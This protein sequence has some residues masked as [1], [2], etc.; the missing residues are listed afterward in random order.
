MV[1]LK[2]SDELAPKEA[3]EEPAMTTLTGRAP[4]ESL[5]LSASLPLLLPPLPLAT[6]LLTSPTFLMLSLTSK[7][8][9]RPPKMVGA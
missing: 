1:S 5:L 9:T 6:P 4:A 2:V 3:V 8:S 7:P